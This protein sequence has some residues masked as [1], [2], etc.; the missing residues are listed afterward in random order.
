MRD[1]LKRT[2]VLGVLAAALGLSAPA[3]AQTFNSGST[4]ADGPF[5]PTCAPTPCTATIALP[6]SGTFNFTTISVNS[7]IT[8]KFTPNANHTPVTMLAS[9]NVTIA[10]TIDVSGAPGGWA[11]DAT[12]LALPNGGA[13]GPGGY[14]GGSGTNALVSQIGGAGLGP[15]GGSG[16]TGGPGGGGGFGAAGGDSSSGAAGGPAYGAPTLLPLIGGSG[17]GGGAAAFG[18]T[19]AGGGGGGGALLI[20]SSGTVTLTGN[21]LARG[22]NGGNCVGNGYPGGGGSGGGIRLVATTITGTG[23]TISVAGGAGGLGCYIWGGA[24]AVGRIRV[25]GL[26]N[27]STVTYN[28]PPSLNQPTLVALPNTPSLTITSI[29]GTATPASPTGSYSTPDITLPSSTTSPVSVAVAASNIPPGTVVTVTSS[30]LAGGTTSA[31]ATLSGTSTS[32]TASTNLTIP[33][34]EPT[35][36]TVS[37]TFMLSAAG[38]GPVYAHGEEV[39][40]V[41][42][43]A[44]LGGPSQIAYVTRSGRELVMTAAR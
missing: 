4:G 26:S 11:S 44:T 25:E 40:R 27:S 41:R 14:S 18:F 7:G 42:V 22:G 35:V 6:V 3:L 12:S 43:S 31:T 34:N 2:I 38:S 30:G 5:N 29:A 32:S 39:E 36:I 1:G 9:G 13:G 37:C 10:G 21:L 15:G 33:T 16:A 8:V 20:A 24:G 28:T 17:G 19:S 23:G